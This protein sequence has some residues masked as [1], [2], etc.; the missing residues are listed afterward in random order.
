MG[1]LNTLLRDLAVGGPVKRENLDLAQ[2][3][4]QRLQS[5]A[6][7]D[8]RQALMAIAQAQDT[9]RRTH[10]AD[11]LAAKDRS[12]REGLAALFSDI[13]QNVA[14]PDLQGYRK[15]AV[16][17][18]LARVGD[19][20]EL[21][22]NLGPHATT[23]QFQDPNTLGFYGYDP[24]QNAIVPVQ[25]PS[26]VVKK[27]PGGTPTAA[28]D[29]NNSEIDQARTLL[30]GMDKAEIIAR[31]KPY[32]ING[33][34][35]PDY[36]P[37]LATSVRRATQR[38]IGADPGFSSFYNGIYGAP[39]PQPEP[40]PGAGQP[41]PSREPRL[42]QHGDT[43]PLDLTMQDGSPAFVPGKNTTIRDPGTGEEQ[44]WTKDAASGKLIRVR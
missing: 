31:T 41:G 36:D 5:R 15:R 32:T 39:A 7:I 30:A 10:T 6:E 9:M 18:E 42:G 16:L 38:K 2:R 40:P 28:Q 23:G 26:G 21:L 27:A 34:N 1:F 11:A 19:N 12:A 37:F 22:A 35:N 44:V 13:P 43:P 4:E 33:R 24:Q 3:Q 25:A 8:R 14:R 29:A 17:Q 20:K